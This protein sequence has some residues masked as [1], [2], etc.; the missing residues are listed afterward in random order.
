MRLSGLRQY[1]VL[2]LALFAAV[3]TAFGQSRSVSFNLSTSKTFAPGEQPSFHLYTHNVDALEFRVYRVDDPVKFMEN[4]RELHSFGAEAGLLGKEQIDERSWLEK[5]HDW[6]AGL[7]D[8]MRSFFKGQFTSDTRHLIRDK[9]GSVIRHSR[10][11]SEAEFA[12]IPILNQSQLV[13]RWRLQVPST[14]ISDSAKLVAPKLP[15]GLYL[16]E[17]TN[18]RY[19]AYTLLMVTQM[20]L[21]TRTTAGRAMAF[22]VDRTTGQ[23]IEG[24][25][26]DV[27]I[28]QKL[29][30]TGV[31]DHGG[32]AE[33]PLPTDKSSPDNFWV[34]AGKGNEFAASTPGGWALNLS[35][36]SKYAG[37]VFTERPVYRPTHTVHW[38]AIVRAREGNSLVVPKGGQVQ[39]K[40]S[41]GSDKAVFDRKMPLSATGEVSGDLELPKDAA[42]GYY[43][44][45]V[46]ASGGSAEN[47]YSG[48]A[49]GFHV[50]DYRKPEYRVQVKPA[51]K[52]VLQGA[53]MA[54][55]IDSRYFFGE[56]VANAKVKYRIYHERH[57]WWG[58][59]ENDGNGAEAA[60]A[61]ED[62]ADADPSS[63]A[64]DEQAEQTGKLNAD[65]ILVIQV[66]TRPE[67]GGNAHPDLDYTVE[68]G[69]TDVANREITGRARFLATYGTFRVHVEPVNYAVHSGDQAK[70]HVTTTDYD[71]QPVSTSVHVQ[72]VFHH[73]QDG[74]TQ[75]IQG[76]AVDVTTNV[77]GQAEGT[78]AVGS[79][80][81]SSAEIE[82]TAAPIQADTRSPAD[83][84]Y[85]WI[86]GA[87]EVGWDSSMQ[88]TQI[89]TDKKSYAPGDT[90]HL[91]IVS[92][93]SEFDA[94]V[95]VEGQTLLKRETMHSAG[96]TLSFELPITAEAMPNLTV[97]A[98]FLKNDTLY[99]AEKDIKVPPA[100]QRLQVQITPAKDIFEPQ[101]MVAHDVVT[102]DA[103]GKPVSADVSVGVVDEA[104]Y[105][106]YPDISGDM[107]RVLYPER[108]VEASVDTSLD[109]FFSGE[110]GDKSPM[111]A[112]RKARYHPQLAQVKPGNEAK[113]RV[114]KAFP[115]TAYWAASVHTDATGH[116]RVS[117][118][119]PDSLT[120]WRTT[121]HA[122][123]TDTKAGSAINRVLVRKNVIVRMGTPRF[124]VKGDEI[125]LPVIVHNYL[126]TPMMA[127]I[128]LKAEG[129]DIISGSDQ[130][131]T[132][133]SKGESTV[134]W[135]LRASRAGTAKL[136]ASAVAAQDSDALELSFPVNPAGV[137]ETLAQSG[138]IA[139]NAPGAT[140]KIAFPSSTDA[141]AHS[142]HV[143]VSSSIAGSLIPALSYL[144]TY[145]Y[146]C[147][148][149]T[150]SS[151]LPNVIVAE[152]LNKLK[153]ANGVDEADVMAK[154]QAGLDR[155]KDYQH[156]DGGWGW[157]KEDESRVSM[158]AY[159][160]AG[161][162]QGARYA[163]V[164]WPHQMMLNEGKTYLQT[165]LGQHPKMRPELRAAVVY[166]L[167]QSETQSLGPELDK[168]WSRRADL[169][170]EALAMTGLA[171]LEVHD[172][173]AAQIATLLAS[174][175]VRQGDLVSWK[176]S[177]LPLLDYDETSDT[178]ATA[179][180][181][182]FLAKVDPV[183]PLLPGAAQWLMLARDGGVW[184]NST[185]ETAMVLFG[186]VDYLA[187][188]HELESDFTVQV[189][190]DNR[191]AGERHFT[192]ADAQSG[193]S[194]AIDIDAAQ[195]QA[196]ENNVQVVR[197]G[198]SGRIYWSA[199]GQYFSTEKSAIQ[200]GS[201]A[202]N[203]TRDY[204]KLQPVQKDGKIVYSLV[205]LTGTAQVG[206]VLAVH[207]AI[208]G[209]PMRYL[210]LE[211]PIPAGVE[212]IQNEASYTIDQRPG[213]WV[214]WFTRREFHDDHAAFFASDFSGRQEI[215]Y[216][217]RVV[218]PGTFAI[219]PA[220][221]Q[222]M[223]QH[224]VQA[225]MTACSFGY[226][227]PEVCSDG[228]VAC[229][230]ERCAEA[231]ERSSRACTAWPRDGSG[232]AVPAV[233]AA[234]GCEHSGSR[235]LGAARIAGCRVGW[236]GREPHHP[237]SCRPQVNIGKAYSGHAAVVGWCC[238]LACVELM[239]RLR[240][241]V[242]GRMKMIRMDFRGEDLRMRDVDG[243]RGRT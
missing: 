138:V 134:Y 243:G 51:Q 84:N 41:D 128:S 113:P 40:I 142:L 229:G 177:Y 77:A 6:K 31:T 240:L 4:L 206:D 106:L 58:E 130:T 16:L 73:W 194:L 234:A 29:L 211:D 11:L 230:L 104:I 162:G 102:R 64:G 94:L 163:K 228:D 221:V 9:Q 111:L 7:W 20:A 140:A 198:G 209:T 119:F 92:Q 30:A 216:L 208:S 237:A 17:A 12:Q 120:T 23:P 63:Y 123:T 204:F 169:Q 129:L 187:A 183:Q 54:V 224:G 81:Y 115:D 219:S 191:V 226:R 150:M 97:T 79:P 178:E 35:G 193:A 153:S 59:D 236:R 38:K 37:Y 78:I 1:A 161:L 96:S 181:M 126:E 75:T 200:A 149:Q 53:T 76:P 85:L 105:S 8:E 88:T 99:Q 82:A 186:L 68:A 28:G 218:N 43:T 19:K 108:S 124:M 2:L 32:T 66:P 164:S 185:E 217:V 61:N 239:G 3:C 14:F 214:D 190:V 212:F 146:G 25:K 139:R 91:S 172:A 86:M 55:T 160:V 220:R 89:V 168:L 24:A 10:I 69:V 33:L 157:W 189:L 39:V 151:Y 71:D 147:T 232:C 175:A 15:A 70:F 110:A 192:T 103:S 67:A 242:A 210:L 13:S 34:V 122:V 56:P 136:T 112:M 202:L 116:A 171:M 137:A 52:R 148:E 201:M 57:Y 5:F 145:P 155:L 133:A 27:G 158:T 174:Q 80:Q 176:G 166:A 18:G 83:E 231:A 179:Y 196:G 107:V 188:S 21:V 199:R 114:R 167:A 87:N 213:G 22:V 98:L 173:R 222:P 156:D 62:A 197:R 144:T 125:S 100:Q 203:L 74:R 143:E 141:A 132:I 72:L 180:A 36:D 135:R 47:V 121:V 235:W 159:V 50:E 152:T 225:T 93:A 26:V 182:R 45:T 154:M 42:L 44:L 90:A 170:P 241:Q 109:Y 65:G 49:C 238:D 165:E 215:F 46:S 223:Y 195:L 117:F 205:P 60:A 101:Q 118:T 207:E 131:A 48:I 227:R 127:K 184:W 233:A 95:I